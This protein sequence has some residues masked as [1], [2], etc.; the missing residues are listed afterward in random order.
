MLP[1]GRTGGN[2]PHGHSAGYLGKPHDPFVL[3]ADPSDP[4]FKVP[5]LLP[6]D[7]IS[8]LRADRRRSLRPV[9]DGAVKGFEA[10]PQARLLDSSFHEAY[11]LISSVRARE[12]FE[13][14]KETDKVKDRYGRNRLDLRPGAAPSPSRAQ[15]LRS[16]RR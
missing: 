6:P 16:I 15:A 8:A 4:S 14:G 3:N 7:Y 13:L 5:D 1:I 12:A 9:V 2:L 10:S 11:N